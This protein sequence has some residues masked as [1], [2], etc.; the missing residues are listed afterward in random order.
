M[1]VH[2]IGQSFQYYFL[3]Y[4]DLLLSPKMYLSP[5]ISTAISMLLWLNSLS[6]GI[7]MHFT[8]LVSKTFFGFYYLNKSQLISSQ[9]FHFFQCF[10]VFYNIQKQ[11][12]GDVYKIDVLKNFAKFTGNLRKFIGLFFNKF[13]R[14]RFPNCNHVY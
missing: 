2:L 14:W 7:V 12:P 11:S 1:L 5:K 13:V 4:F 6:L 8:N 9:S 3:V 10:A